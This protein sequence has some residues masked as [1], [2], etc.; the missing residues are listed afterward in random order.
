MNISDS[1]S[2][3]LASVSATGER[4]PIT[5]ALTEYQ[6]PRSGDIGSAIR[7]ACDTRPTKRLA[8]QNTN[9]PC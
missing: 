5:G 9:P 1:P 3:L 2:V 4:S 6:E 7:A 8:T